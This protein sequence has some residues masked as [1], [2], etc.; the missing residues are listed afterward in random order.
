M[1]A[2]AQATIDL[3]QY[4]TLLAERQDAER[5]LAEARRLRA[6]A[7]QLSG[8]AFTDEARALAS[9]HAAAARAA[10]LSCTQLLAERTR[11]AD[12]L[13]SSPHLARALT[14]R[15]RL[16]R[17]QAEAAQRA[18]AERAGR[19]R[20]TTSF[21]EFCTVSAAVSRSDAAAVGLAALPS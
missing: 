3:A 20:V 13:A 16:A 1:L 12:E 4:E 2:P 15:R 8:E 11:F 10:E 21:R 5:A 14:E 19:L 18:E 9:Q 6:V 17:E 7:E